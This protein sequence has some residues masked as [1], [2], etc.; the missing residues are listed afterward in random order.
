MGLDCTARFGMQT[1]GPSTALRLAARDVVPLGMTGRGET[2]RAARFGMQTQGPST[3][4]R[5]ATRDVVPLGIT[6]GV[7]LYCPLW[8]ANAR[9]LDCT[10]SRCARRRSARVP[11]LHSVSLRETSFRSGSQREG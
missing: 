4:L 9:S 7:R 11:R 8:N 5:L 10:P 1:Q 6:D 2:A 3:A